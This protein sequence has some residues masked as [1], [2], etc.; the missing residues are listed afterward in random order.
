VKVS[1]YEATSGGPE[2]RQSLFLRVVQ[3]VARVGG[4]TLPKDVKGL[5]LRAEIPAL[6]PPVHGSGS[7]AE[8]P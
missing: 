6:Q 7:K 4:I 8:E 1:E 3:E 2:L 5:A